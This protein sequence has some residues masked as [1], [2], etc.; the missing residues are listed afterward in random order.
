MPFLSLRIPGVSVPLPPSAH[1][2]T[3]LRARDFDHIPSDLGTQKRRLRRQRILET[4]LPCAIVSALLVAAV[5]TVGHVGVKAR[6]MARARAAKMQQQTSL[7][8]ATE[9]P[10]RL[11]RLLAAEG[12]QL[13]SSLMQVK[14]EA[15]ATATTA[16]ASGSSSASSSDQQPLTADASD[17]SS[18]RSSSSQA[19]LTP[20]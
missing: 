1:D 17:S 18:R 4:A 20:G 6:A 7:L 11:E 19:A 3:M 15:T 9:P 16:D 10:S 12:E 13:P 14:G 8:S 2:T 5:F